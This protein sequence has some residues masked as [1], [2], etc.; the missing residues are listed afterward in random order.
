MADENDKRE[1]EEGLTLRVKYDEKSLAPAVVQDV[2][3]GEILMLA[4]VNEEAL[5]ETLRSGFA[6]FWSRSRKKLWTKGKT[7][8]DLLKIR[9]VL[10]DCDQDALIYRVEKLGKGACHTK[11]SQGNTRNSCFYRKIRE[12][13]QGLEFI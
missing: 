10:V 8:G 7:S 4:Y 1:S 5:R 13:G 3:S 2:K 12:D 11:D 9:E 6:T